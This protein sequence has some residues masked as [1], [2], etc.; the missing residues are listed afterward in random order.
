METY[1]IGKYTPGQFIW[2][3]WANARIWWVYRGG[4]S[5]RTPFV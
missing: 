3:R 2:G 1:K 4:A 5:S